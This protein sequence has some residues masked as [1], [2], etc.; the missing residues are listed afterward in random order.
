L[1]RLGDTYESAGDPAARDAWQ[2]ALTIFD[3]LRRPDADDVRA[4]LRGLANG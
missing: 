2:E 4:R 1:Q 3:D